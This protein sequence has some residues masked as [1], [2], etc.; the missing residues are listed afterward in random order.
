MA[1]ATTDM[2]LNVKT[3]VGGGMLE[4]QESEAR[5]EEFMVDGGGCG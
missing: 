3:S 4:G 2:P 5:E 1:G